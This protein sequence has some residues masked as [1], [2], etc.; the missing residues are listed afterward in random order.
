VQRVDSGAAPGIG[1]T[2]LIIVQITDTHLLAIPPANDLAHRRAE[3]LRRCVA[4]INDLDPLPDAVIHTG[5]LTHEGEPGAYAIARDILGELVPPCFPIPGNCDSRALLA[6]YFEG[7]LPKPP[8]GDAVQYAVDDFPLRLVGVDTQGTIGHEGHYDDARVR[9]LAELLGAET[10]KPTA[11]FMHHAP[12]AMGSEPAAF[13]LSEGAER[14]AA[15]IANHPQV[16]RVF[17]GH[18]HAPLR[19][20]VGAALG[21]SAPATAVDRRSGPFPESMRDAPVY[22]IHVFDRDSGFASHTRVVRRSKGVGDK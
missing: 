12:F 5:D 3:D 20:A 10:A 14:L 17:C 21:T 7:R 1:L 9:E 18:H 15:E 11:L 8:G 2:P 16:I 6:E 22:E 13:R 19:G 4:D